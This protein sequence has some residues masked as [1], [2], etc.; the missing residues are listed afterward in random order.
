MDEQLGLVEGGVDLGV[1]AQRGDGRGHHIGQVREGKAFLFLEGCFVGVAM[2]D[3]T[4]H[5]RVLGLPGV[6]DSRL[7]ADHVLGDEASHP[8]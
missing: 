1:L 5:V 2:R 6:G 3:H 4:G 7:R 8:R